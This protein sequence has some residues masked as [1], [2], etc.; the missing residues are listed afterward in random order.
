MIEIVIA[1]DDN[2]V[3]HCGVVMSSVV[4]NAAP[5]TKIRFHIISDG[6]IYENLQKF[7]S[8]ANDNTEVRFV[9]VD[10]DDFRNCPLP[11]GIGISQATYYRLK[12]AELLPDLDKALYLDCDVIV[13]RDLTDLWET[14]ISGYDAAGVPDGIDPQESARR[15]GL[16]PV[17][18]FYSNAGVMLIN[19]KRWRKANLQE[20]FFRFIEENYSRINFPDQDVLNY[21][22]QGNILQLPTVWNVQYFVFA[23]RTDGSKET[24]ALLHNAAILHFITTSKPWS[25]YNQHPMRGEYLTYLLKSPWSLNAWQILLKFLLTFLCCYRKTIFCNRLKILG[26]TIVKAVKNKENL[27]FIHLFNLPFP[28]WIINRKQ[29]A[30]QR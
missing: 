23:D 4:C 27:I 5:D 29:E 15:T 12:M 21:C 19:L 22:L 18:G 13:R 1:T 6:L 24:L 25:F 28:I 30:N 7:Q 8:Y 26:M 10:P 14:D 16:P 20:K 9:Y 11:E 17:Q 2:Y 3:Q